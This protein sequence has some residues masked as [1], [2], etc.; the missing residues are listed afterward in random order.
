MT[1]GK[2]LLQVCILKVLDT[3]Y[4]LQYYGI[5][6]WLLV[7]VRVPGPRASGVGKQPMN[8]EIRSSAANW[9]QHNLTFSWVSCAEKS[10]CTCR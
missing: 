8:P 2:L 5:E 3:Q 7:R 6:C 10:L 4:S 9:D 1:I